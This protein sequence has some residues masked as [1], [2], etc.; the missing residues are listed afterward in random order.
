MMGK[1]Q[2]QD[3]KKLTYISLYGIEA[4]QKILTQHLNQSL[5]YLKMLELE[6]TVS[7]GLVHAMLDRVR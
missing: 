6:D 5:D 1:P 4:T 3:E 2:G 7:E